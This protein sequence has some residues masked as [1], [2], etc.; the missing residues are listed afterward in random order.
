MGFDPKDV[1]IWSAD[2]TE[3]DLYR[4][5]GEEPV[6]Q[7][8]KLDRGFLTEWGLGAIGRLQKELG[9]KAFADAKLVEIPTKLVE[10]TKMH[11]KHRPWM[12][13]AMAGCI[14]N[15]NYGIA[16]EELDGL[17]RFA[18]LCHEA[19]TLPC[20]VTVLTSKTPS[21][22]LLEFGRMPVDQVLHYVGELL[23][24]GF[25]DIVCSPQEAAAI[26]KDSAFDGL[27]LNCPGIRLPDSSA[28]DQARIMTPAAAMAAGVDR[29]VIGR[30]LTKGDFAANFGRIADNLAFE[31]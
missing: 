9:V 26:R 15:G 17:K 3:T 8:V 29:M 7:Y 14:S 6:I 13:N 27:S 24:A 10:L 19:G 20:G 5:L 1:V 12:L 4:I 16:G 23:E 11:L 28:D 31:A 30:D 18:D 2:V 22:S 21:V 25:T